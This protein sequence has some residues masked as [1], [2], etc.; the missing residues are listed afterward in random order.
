MSHTEAITALRNFFEEGLAALPFDAEK[1]AQEDEDLTGFLKDLRA[2]VDEVRGCVIEAEESL[3]SVTG[4]VKT[5]A[6]LQADLELVRQDLADP[7]L[8]RSTRRE[9]RT[10]E[11]EILSELKGCETDHDSY[12]GDLVNQVENVLNAIDFPK[13]V[14]RG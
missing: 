3:A 1:I 14:E 10:E 5:A 11:R 9:R 12:A 6:K 13:P 7:D 4:N 2:W 8:D